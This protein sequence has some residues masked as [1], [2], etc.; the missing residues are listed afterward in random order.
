MGLPARREAPD[1]RVLVVEDEPAIAQAV[2][3]A[4]QADGHAVDL[5]GDGRE[6]L[7]WAETYA[8]DLVVLD[9]VLP[10]LNG[11]EVCDRLRASGFREPILMLTAL[12]G[13][14]HRVAGLDRGADDYLAKPFAMTELRARIRALG[15]RTAPERAPRLVV[16]DLELE[17]STLGVIRGGQPVRLTAREFALLEL[18]ARHPGQIFGRERLI[19]ALWDAEFAAE[20]NVV[21]VYIRSLRRKVDGGRR[22]GLIETIR[23]AGY[24]L[25]VPEQPAPRP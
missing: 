3:A 22:N 9:I 18:L 11:L 16:G 20:S 15:R 17:P 19:D 6:A 7:T 10:G 24:R 8:Y 13:V 1:L 14:E 23:G 21:E 4:L 5:V 12:D 2:R 25:R